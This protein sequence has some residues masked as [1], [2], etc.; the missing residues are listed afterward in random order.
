MLALIDRSDPTVFDPEAFSPQ[1][2]YALADEAGTVHIR[3]IEA[4][5]AGWRVVGRM[6]YA[7]MPHVKRAGEGGGGFAEYSDEFEF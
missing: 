2:F 5:P 4:L 3:W 6:L 1:E 7:Q